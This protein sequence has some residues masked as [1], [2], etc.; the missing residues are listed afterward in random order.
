MAGK[1]LDDH[2]SNQ[3]HFCLSR[4]LANE[5][6]SDTIYWSFSDSRLQGPHNPY[7]LY[8]HDFCIIIIIFPHIYNKHSVD[9]T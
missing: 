2:T 5:W 8:N 4:V 6:V 9:Y 3:S 7:K 1:I